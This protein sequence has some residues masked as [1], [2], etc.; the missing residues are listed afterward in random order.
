MK[1]LKKWLCL[2]LCIVMLLTILPTVAM[3]A[4][5]ETKASIFLTDASFNGST[6]PFGQTLEIKLT[7]YRGSNTSSY[8]KY[9]VYIEDGNSNTYLSAEDYVPSY[10]ITDLTLTWEVDLAPGKYYIYA[11][12]SDNYSDPLIAYFYIGDDIDNHFTDTVSGKQT[13]QSNNLSNPLSAWKN[14]ASTCQRYSFYEPIP[15]EIQL[16]EMYTGRVANAI[17]RYENM[18]NDTSTEDQQW[19]LMRFHLKNT[20]NSSLL[21]YAYDIINKNFFYTQSGASMTVTDTASFSKDRNGMGVYDVNLY[22]GGSADVWIG[23]LVPK[24]QG[25]PL[26]QIST[27]YSNGNAQIGWL[28]TTPVI[29]APTITTQPASVSVAAGET[30]KFSVTA[31]GRSLTYQW[32]QLKT[33]SGS[34]ETMSGETSSSLSVYAYAYQNGRKYRCIITN[35]AGTV[36]SN[37]ATL[38]VLTAPSIT[39]HPQ[40]VTVEQDQ[41]ATFTVTASGTSPLNYQWQQKKV[42][43]SW[44]DMSGQTTD[45]LKVTGYRSYNGRQYRCVVSNSL[46]TVT[47]DA[48]TLTVLTAPVIT[49]HPQNVA[50]EQDQR[51]TF[52]VTA[53]GTSPLSYQ[54]QQKKVG[55]SWED[56]SGQTTETLKVTGYR[57]YNGRQYRCVVSNS[58]GTVTSDAATLTVL[59]AP[60]I[61]EHP[62]NVAVEQDQRATFTVTASGTSPLNYQ[63]Q[64]KK[65]GGS[66]EDMSGQ[67][68][69]SLKVT[70]YKSYNGRQYRC[71]VSNSF[72][73]ET[74]N[75][76]TLTVIIPHDGCPCSMFEDMPPYGT[77]EH[78]AIDWAFTHNPQI[79]EGMD[80][81]H[82][83]YGQTVT[84]AQAMRFLW[85]AAGQPEPASTENPFEDIIEGKWYYLPVM[86]A[87]NNENRITDGMD[88]THFGINIGCS[89]AHII[90]FLW[91]AMGKPEPTIENPYTD[92]TKPD[93]SGRFYTSAAIWAY[94]VG[95]EKGE[96]GLFNPNIDCTRESVVVYLYRYFTG[97]GLMD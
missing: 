57:S 37:A 7:I 32:Q 29:S 48:A 53:S 51:A 86:W 45:T 17:V 95:I 92:I 83:G 52:T 77:I 68:T 71:I 39:Q 13:A 36:T 41:R 67:T 33:S 5:A 42:G 91:N 30:A 3:K 61:T 43:G 80:E 27:G 62:Q 23:I 73:T 74:S 60:V 2:A 19:I 15:Y 55:G 46:G 65:V 4:E 72:G 79:T 58:L 11:Y 26:L 47:S 85:N 76:A 6:I 22:G 21:L 10:Y 40:S 49:E 64:Q 44:E 82:F 34:W 69:E 59:T 14:T 81:T 78:T 38:T 50:V 97:E 18:Y 16:V 8:L 96:N 20:G 31:K 56:M 24:S 63:W 1:Q 70:G 84:R 66:W 94:E 9:Y 90:T 89:R 75:A 87:Y 28:D 12:T 93:G 54:W 25:Y 88:N 35:S